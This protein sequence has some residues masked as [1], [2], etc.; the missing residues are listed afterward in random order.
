MTSKIKSIKKNFL[1]WN[2]DVLIASFKKINLNIILIV[3]LDILFYLMSSFIFIFWLQKM[4]EKLIGFNLP[5]DMTV[6]SS[7]QVQQ[8]LS[9][10]K[11]FYYLLVFSF[12]LVVVIIIFLASILKGIIWAKTTNTKISLALVSKF[13][14]LNL[15]WMVFWFALIIMISLFVEQ[16]SEPIFMIVA[17]ISAFYFTNTL[18]SIFM[19]SP[20][21]KS[22]FDAI[23][24]NIAKIHLF[25]L[26]YS[27]TFLL[28]FIIVRTSNLVAFKY[29][30]ILFNL[31]LIIYAAIVRYYVSSLVLEIEKL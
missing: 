4:Q 9:E 1:K 17:L 28:F 19:R 15:I 12:I 25:L 27:I 5:N 13:L 14:G 26:P 18:Y 7:E 6:L 20:T 11:T 22:I 2:S 29:S 8:L 16:K 24:L 23:K 21:F 10:A 30:S 3:I 31:V